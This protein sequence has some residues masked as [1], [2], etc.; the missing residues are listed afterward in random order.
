MRSALQQ[1]CAC[2][3][4]ELGGG[5]RARVTFAAAR[6][7]QLPRRAAIR[8]RSQRPEE[9]RNAEQADHGG[10]VPS[11]Q[12]TCSRRPVGRLAVALELRSEKIENEPLPWRCTMYRAAMMSALLAA[13]CLAQTSFGTITGSVIDSSGGA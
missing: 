6:L 3:Q 8:G 7:Q 13:Q 1:A 12:D 10:R 5:F 11:V 4:V 2:A 9:E